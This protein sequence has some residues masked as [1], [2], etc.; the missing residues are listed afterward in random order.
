MGPKPP[1]NGV[2]FCSVIKI[3]YKLTYENIN[4]IENCDKEYEHEIK[5]KNNNKLLY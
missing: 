1:Q 2:F 4:K 3:K 5:Y